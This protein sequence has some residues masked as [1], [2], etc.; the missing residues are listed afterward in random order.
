MCRKRNVVLASILVLI[1]LIAI[2]FTVPSGALLVEADRYYVEH[3][4]EEIFE[5]DMDEGMGEGFG[6]SMDPMDW[7]AS[8]EG[9]IFA[10][11][12]DFSP[13]SEPIEENYTQEGYTDS[14]ISVKMKSEKVEKAVYHV[15]H[16]KLAHGSQIRTA[17]AG[18]FGTKKTSKP[19]VM[20]KS[21]HEIA[22][23]TGDY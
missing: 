5:E 18:P 22:A 23:I 8:K 10:L 1:C 19:S 15:A 9:M 13:G 3:T 12:I 14:T 4:P 16:I 20:A 21:N 6:S 17:L 11:P 7:E 2:P